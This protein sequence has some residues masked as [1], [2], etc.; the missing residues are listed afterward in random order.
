MKLITVQCFWKRMSLLFGSKNA[1]MLRDRDAMAT[2]DS[3]M[4][5]EEKK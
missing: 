2:A 1:D 4:A 5:R 3:G